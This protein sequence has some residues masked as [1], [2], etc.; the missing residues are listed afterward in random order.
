MY[1][2]GGTLFL[3]ESKLARNKL[4]GLY[5]NMDCFAVITD[6][7][8]KNNAMGKC[9]SAIKCKIKGGQFEDPIIPPESST[10]NI[11]AK[12]LK[13]LN[14]GM[15]LFQNHLFPKSQQSEG[16]GSLSPI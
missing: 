2:L 7:C 15:S 5:L 6:C 1:A 13:P 3:S 8:F 14:V 9:S 4:F 12:E 10:E 16:F 11:V